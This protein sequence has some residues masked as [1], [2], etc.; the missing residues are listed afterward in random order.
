MKVEFN[1]EK[2]YSS[3]KTITKKDL[4]KREIVK[5]VTN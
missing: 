5:K 3:I 1:K 2:A 4:K